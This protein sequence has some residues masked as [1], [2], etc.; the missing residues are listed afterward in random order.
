MSGKPSEERFG[1]G[2]GRPAGRWARPGL[3]GAECTWTAE[4]HRRPSGVE[5]FSL[6]A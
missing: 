4:G 2:V 6:Q 3:P 5:A 1:V